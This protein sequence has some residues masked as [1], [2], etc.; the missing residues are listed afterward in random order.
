MTPRR[1]L[2]GW[3]AALVAVL[4]LIWHGIWIAHFGTPLAVLRSFPWVLTHM[5]E[6]LSGFWWDMFG[7]LPFVL[8]LLALL[9][10]RRSSSL[11][12]SHP[13]RYWGV[14]AVALSPGLCA[15]MALFLA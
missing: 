7:F 10:A 3:S 13:M 8:L 6:R 15:V 1:H 12:Q 5:D 14:L 11:R 2:T 4:A 9:F